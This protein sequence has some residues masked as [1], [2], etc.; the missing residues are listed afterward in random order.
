MEAFVGIGI[1]LAILLLVEGIY[2]VV[3]NRM[4]PEVKHLRER[5]KVLSLT[6]YSEEEV[7]LLRKKTLSQVP[8]LNRLLL[9]IRWAQKLDQLLQQADI[10]HPVGLF[11][12]LSVLLAS[13]GGLIAA[14]VTPVLVLPAIALLGLV[15]FVY[16]Y[17]KK[18]KRMRKFERQLPDTM[19][20]I[21]RALKAGH[22]LSGGLQLVGEEF[23][24]P[25]GTEFQR[26]VNEINFGVAVPDA[27]KALAQR[28]DCKDLKFFVMSVIIQ[29]ETGGNLAE[30]LE[31][32][33]RLIRERFKLQGRI[34]VLSA[35]GK[36]S[37]VILVAIPFFLGFALS[38]IN[39]DYINTLFE[40]PIGIVLLVF[41]SVMMALGILMMKK[42][43][44]IR[45]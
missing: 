35:E 24:D 29:R 40:D 15:P 6:N 42:M 38:I 41:A 9:S 4:N 20:L 44:A 3:R 18:R 39:P 26:T 8:W 13:G 1:F 32:I 5:L 16:I 14:F 23:G 34:R 22:A 21:A 2:L 7:D 30:I 28:V 19:D 36:L 31:N 17:V 27:L 37:A 12:L 43:V 33:A 25:I 10:R 11:I 45:V